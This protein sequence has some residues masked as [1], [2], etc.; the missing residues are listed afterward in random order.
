MAAEHRARHARR[1]PRRPHVE[2]HAVRAGDEIGARRRAR[3]ARR[4]LRRNR[5]RSPSAPAAGCARASS[6]PK[7]SSRFTTACFSDLP[8]EQARLRFPVAPH[9]AVVVEMVAREVGEQRD[10]ELDAGHAVL[11]EPD[12]GHLHRH[13]LRAA[14]REL[15]ELRVQPQR[16]GRG[17]GEG[18]RTA[19]AGRSRACRSPRSAGRRAS[20][21]ARSTGCRWSCRWCRSRR[22]STAGALGRPWT[23]LAISPACRRRS[24]H[25]EVG[26]PPRGFHANPRALPQHAAPRR[27]RSPARCNRGRRATRPG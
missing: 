13:R 17:V 6:A 10:V 4:A 27:S 19:R 14:A 24:A 7:S 25:A 2:A 22:S 16:V 21:P 12:R 11:V 15:R 23:R 20:A 26:H 1:A 5:S 9:R 8:R 18:L 3:A